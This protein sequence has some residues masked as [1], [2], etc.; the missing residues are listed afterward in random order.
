MFRLGFMVFLNNSLNSSWVLYR[1]KF[2]ILVK[3]S[4]FFNESFNLEWYCVLG[5]RQIF[6]D[7][8]HFKK[9]K[10]SWSFLNFKK[11]CILASLVEQLLSC[12]PA[13]VIRHLRLSRESSSILCIYKNRC[14]IKQLVIKNQKVRSSLYKLIAIWKYGNKSKLRYSENFVGL[15]RKYAVIKRKGSRSV[16]N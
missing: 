16:F 1:L 2:S 14:W 15:I 5:R 10:S 8:S 4:V 9:I 12:K 11:C 6:L 7:L 3:S 13:S